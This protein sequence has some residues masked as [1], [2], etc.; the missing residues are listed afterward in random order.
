MSINFTA[1]E[2]NA[3]ILIERISDPEN[4][5]LLWGFGPNTVKLLDLLRSCSG[6]TPVG[7]FDTRIAKDY[8]SEMFGIPTVSPDNLPDLFPIDNTVIIVTCGLNELYGDIVGRHLFYYR[9]VHRRAI[10]TAVSLIKE[11]KLLEENLDYFADDESRS[12]YVSRIEFLIAGAL[13]NNTPASFVS[14]I[15][16][17]M[18]FVSFRK[19][20][21]TR[22]CM[23]AGILNEP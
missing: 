22:A 20:G 3:R 11:R 7:I 18:S 10:E 1:S 2:K 9:V 16:T 4:R 23:M 5:I 14:L 6:A 17:T 13:V 21:S 15:L 8:P 12:A 19:L